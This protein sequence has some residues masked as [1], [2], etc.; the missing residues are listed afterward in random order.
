MQ[1]LPNLGD[2]TT[3]P[4]IV[5]EDPPNPE[6][7][8]DIPIIVT[9]ASP[10]LEDAPAIP[11]IGINLDNVDLEDMSVCKSALNSMA[12]ESIIQDGAGSI[13]SHKNGYSS[14]SNSEEDDDNTP[15]AEQEE[16]E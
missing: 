11:A 10:N 2:A 9:E 5:T 15:L 12:D 8:V 3:I 13:D 1:A 16:R 7:I 6:D 14:S 4:A